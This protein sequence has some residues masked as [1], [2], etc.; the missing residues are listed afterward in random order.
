[1][2]GFVVV[3]GAFEPSS[4]V[5]I[6]SDLEK[7]EDELAELTEDFWL[8]DS[9]LALIGNDKV[10]AAITN[11]F[12]TKI[13][14][15]KAAYLRISPMG[16]S[17]IRTTRQTLH[18]DYGGGERIGDFRNSCACWVNVGF[19]M[20]PLTVEHGPLWVVPGSHHLVNLVPDTSMEFLFEKAKM[21]LVNAGDAVIFHSFV[22]HCGDANRSSTTRHAFFLSHRP[23][24]AKH[25]GPVR[26]WSEDLLM[27]VSPEKRELL[28][29]LNKGL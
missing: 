25:V 8:E 5:Q 15:F 7:R 21:L 12:G 13:K 18:I 29:D 23:Y 19:Y 1:M 3:P 26:E 16:K 14:L 24:W 4:I 10:V 6:V 20:T 9:F 17:K 2:N 27:R 28:L 11:I 22:A